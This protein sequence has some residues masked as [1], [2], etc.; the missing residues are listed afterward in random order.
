MLSKMPWLVSRRKI[1]LL[2]L[3]DYLIII[4]TFLI[5]ENLEIINTNFLAVNLLSFCWL[6]T[7]YTLDKYSIIEDEN[8][9]NFFHSL[10]RTI[11]TFIFVGVLF[12]IIIIIFSFL[13]SDVGDGKWLLFLSITSSLTFLYELFHNYLINKYQSNQ[14]QWISIFSDIDKGS[15]ISKSI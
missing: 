1:L 6:I 3:I 14:L 7:S 15:L 4:F 12:K 11:K 13:E 10:F 5:L 8:I 9:I 2:S